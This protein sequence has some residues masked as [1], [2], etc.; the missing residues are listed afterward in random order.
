M[1][2]SISKKE[3]I[4]SVIFNGYNSIIWIYYFIMLFINPKLLFF[5]TLVTYHLNSFYLFI[6]LISDV[7]LFVFKSQKLEKLNH[8]MRNKYCNVVNPVS[9]L[10]TILYWTLLFTG[11]ITDIKDFHDFLVNLYL[12]LVISIFIIIE[13]LSG[14]HN[15]HHFSKINILFLFIYLVLYC[16]D[17]G[18]AKYVFNSPPYIF[19]EESTV[20]VLLIYASVFMVVLVLCY[21]FHIFLLKMKYKYIAKCE[22]DSYNC[23]NEG[24]INDLNSNQINNEDKEKNDK[25]ETEKD[26]E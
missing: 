13:L 4:I 19:V 14:N 6:C 17:C 18:I 24:L 20:P 15:R 26:I 21:L 8:F 3:F 23:L 1:R 16:I 11:G 9:Y 25:G 2:A 7:S 5:L 10:V 12:H 22:E